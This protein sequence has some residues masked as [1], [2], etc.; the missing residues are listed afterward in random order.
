MTKDP[1]RNYVIVE[2]EAPGA[3]TLA[4]E[5]GEENGLEVKKYPAEWSKYG[6][7]AGYLRNKQMLDENPDID[8]VLAFIDK[9]LK[10]SKGTY[11]M[12]Q[13]ARS[14]GIEVVGLPAKG[15]EVF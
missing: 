2:G 9:P 6:R 3:D 12:Y 13:L 8:V 10:Q 7:K 4:R 14:R 15:V 1:N 5:Y 11:N